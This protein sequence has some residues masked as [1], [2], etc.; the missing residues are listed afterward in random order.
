MHFR[1]LALAFPMLLGFY[2]VGAR[3]PRLADHGKARQS[4]RGFT[5]LPE[6]FC[7]ILQDNPG[8]HGRTSVEVA[9]HGGN[10]GLS[11]ATADGYLAFFTSTDLTDP[12]FFRS[13]SNSSVTT[14]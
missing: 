7:R 13:L 4:L 10:E 1:R 5:A 11:R 6:S 12:F 3:R 2:H 9:R 14:N 8:R